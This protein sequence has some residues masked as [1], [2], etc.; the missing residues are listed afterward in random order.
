M[1]EETMQSVTFPT[2]RRGDLTWPLTCGCEV[3]DVASACEFRWPRNARGALS[4]IDA[5]AHFTATDR[6]R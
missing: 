2:A 5:G 4:R 6:G 1:S 3:S